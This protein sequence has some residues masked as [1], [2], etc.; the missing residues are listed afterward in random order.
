LVPVTLN[1][2]VSQWDSGRYG[3][4]TNLLYIDGWIDWGADGSFADPEDHVLSG[5]DDPSTWGQNYASRGYAFAGWLPAD[6]NLYSR[7]RVNY[8]EGN[9]GYSGPANYGE[10]ED[11]IVLDIVDDPRDGKAPEPTTLLLLPVALLAVWNQRLF[12]KRP[13][14]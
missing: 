7:W 8:G 13:R 2:A 9:M 6:T 4:G 5:T 11:H 12:K 3:G 14:A 10:V 1:L